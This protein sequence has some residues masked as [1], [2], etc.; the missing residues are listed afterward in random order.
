VTDSLIMAY[1]QI[2]ARVRTHGIRV[3]GATLLP[4]GGNDAY[5]D[6]GGLRE[7]TRQTVNRWI[8]TS[9]RFDEVIDFDA[10]T[11]DPHHPRRLLTDLDGGDHLHLNPTGFQVLAEAVGLRLF[12]R[13][14]ISPDAGCPRGTAARR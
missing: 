6:A 1:D 14:A 12:Q 11:R 10:V 7:R 13:S 8:R 4:F 2:V 5:D 3:Y 9:G